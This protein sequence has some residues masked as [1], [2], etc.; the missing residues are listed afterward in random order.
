M[1]PYLTLTFADSSVM[2]CVNFVIFGE[3][4]GEEGGFQLYGHVRVAWRCVSLPVCSDWLFV[5]VSISP[6]AGTCISSLQQVHFLLRG[7][8]I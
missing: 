8:F 4:T 3:A 6:A 2:Q 7:F 5:Q 1:V